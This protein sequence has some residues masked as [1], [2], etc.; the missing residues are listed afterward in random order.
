MALYAV[1][2]WVP[3]PAWLRDPKCE[4]LHQHLAVGTL[5]QLFFNFLEPTFIVVLSDEAMAKGNE[6]RIVAS[7]CP[8]TTL[9][10][11]KH[12]CRIEEVYVLMLHSDA[13][14][15][16]SDMRLEGEQ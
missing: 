9:E 12:S 14:F 3:L 11:G 2:R 4:G 1:A 15:R 16:A 5:D 10:F 7:Y 8:L 6:A 13:T